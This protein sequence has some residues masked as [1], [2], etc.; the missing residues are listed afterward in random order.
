MMMFLPSVSHPFFK[1]ALPMTEKLKERKPAI[2]EHL[3]NGLNAVFGTVS[4]SDIL[5]DVSTGV[6][7]KNPQVRGNSVKLLSRR[8]KETRVAPVKSEYKAF[9]EMMLKTLDDADGGAREASAEGLGTL[10]K[11]VGEKA[12][13]PWTEGLD[14]IKMG[15]IKEACEKAEVKA[16]PVVAKKPAPAPA[17]KKTPAKPAM[18][19][20]PAAVKKAAPPPKSEP[21]PMAIDDDSAPPPTMSPPKRKPPARLAGS[22]A[23]KPTLSSSKPKSA[24]STAA[25]ASAGPKKAAKLPPSSGPEEVRYKFTQEDA[26]ARAT[27]FIPEQIW[28]DV[29]QSQWKVRLAAMESLY[30]HFSSMDPIDTE[31]EIVFRALSKKPGWKEMN[32]Q[33]MGKLFGVLQLLATDC[34]KFN[35]ACVAIAVQGMDIL[36]R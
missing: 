24:S 1:V 29:A 23:K 20:K 26:E 25:S 11:V 12:L 8:L 34:P 36:Q 35:K 4:L 2:V 6:K 15:K 5:E 19:P 7:H 16:K 32:F 13:A 21:E 17:P 33:V 28:N 14:D 30:T 27:E 3:M 9:A 10:M 18:K 22:S 31:P